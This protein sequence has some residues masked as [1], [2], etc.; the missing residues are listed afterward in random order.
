MYFIKEKLQIDEDKI[1]SIVKSICLMCVQSC[2]HKV[3][4]T[5]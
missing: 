5:E 1:V 2:K 3:S 4:L